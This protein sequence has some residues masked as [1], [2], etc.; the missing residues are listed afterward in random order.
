LQLSVV[1]QASLSMSV[2]SFNFHL[3][4]TDERRTRR[5]DW[6]LSQDAAAAMPRLHSRLSAPFR[7]G[8]LIDMI[9][10]LL[11]VGQSLGIR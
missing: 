1:M 6:L 11:T 10:P 7:W 2:S 8:R 9:G 3:Q 5:G 4:R